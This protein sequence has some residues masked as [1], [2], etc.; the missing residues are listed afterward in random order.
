MAY[1]DRVGF[2]KRDETVA[3]RLAAPYRT[4]ARHPA[5]TGL[6]GAPKFTVVDRPRGRGLLSGS[7]VR[8]GYVPANPVFD[9]IFNR[10]LAAL[11]LILTAPIL[12]LVW[13]MLRIGGGP[14]LYAGA[15]LGRDRQIFH[16]LKFRTLHVGAQK[17]LSGG[18]LPKRSGLETGLGSYLRK[19]R[20][21]ELPQLI[22]ILRGEMVFFG[23]RPVRPELVPIYRAQ[24]DSFEARFAVRP[25]LVGLTQA[26]LPHSASKR[27][28]GR[29][30][31]MCCAAPVRYGFLVKFV[32]LVGLSVLRRALATV[33]EAA[34]AA[35]SPT[36][37]FAFLRSGFVRPRDADAMIAIGG[38]MQTGAI[39]AMSDEV[40]QLVFSRPV[41]TGSC[42]LVLTRK[43]RSGRLARLEVT[44]T[45]E[46][47]EPVGVGQPGFVV[48]AT[49]TPQSSFNRYRM[50]RYF[51][52]QTVLPA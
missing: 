8:S 16:I 10:G 24:S 19:S 42:T 13:T 31:A 32:A 41:D 37:R 3:S 20:I 40:L 25:G 1:L 23:P 51:L 48:F 4:I 26:L 52:D 6:R 39:L 22:N 27:L 29:F 15:R 2:A 50:E 9:A 18:T 49:F 46:R 11:C 28:R 34:R 5:A 14:A 21:D 7:V 45:V 30:N 43:L 44:G 33:W 17:T 38:E 36:G 47:V 12:V 35:V